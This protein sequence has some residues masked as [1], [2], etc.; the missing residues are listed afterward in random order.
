MTKELN[1]KK[2]D[3]IHGESFPD[4]VMYNDDK[5][6]SI[7]YKDSD[8][9]IKN[10]IIRKNSIFR[11]HSVLNYLIIIRGL[12]NFF[13]GSINQLIARNQIYKK[14]NVSNGKI[15][16]FSSTLSVIL[17]FTFEFIRNTSKLFVK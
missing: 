3:F 16:K 4:G 10:K 13:E 5:Y 12:I 6:L 2:N 8:K 9:E 7:T 1:V 15:N 14:I 17:I 11:K